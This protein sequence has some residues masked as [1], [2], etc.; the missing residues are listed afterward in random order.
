MS[1]HV[2]DTTN[3]INWFLI[4]HLPAFDGKFKKKI[5][6][7]TSQLSVGVVL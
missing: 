7:A 4:E 1:K 2:N 5:F 6:C 3:K